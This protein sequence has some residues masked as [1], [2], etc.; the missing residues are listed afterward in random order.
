MTAQFKPKR[1]SDLTTVVEFDSVLKGL[2]ATVRYFSPDHNREVLEAATRHGKVNG[3]RYHRG[4]CDAIVEKLEG[5]TEP[6][7]D[8]L[9]ALE[10]E[11]ARPQVGV[12]PLIHAPP[13][14]LFLMWQH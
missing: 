8:P 2:V 3:E 13:D 14:V 12:A 4:R 9:V 7:P 11:S 6:I 10:P 1:H 5:L